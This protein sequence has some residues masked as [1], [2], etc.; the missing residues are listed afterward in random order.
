MSPSL[1]NV[2]EGKFPCLKAAQSPHFQSKVEAFAAKQQALDHLNF[3]ATRAHQ[4][5]NLSILRESLRTVAFTT[6]IDRILF[7]TLTCPQGMTDKQASKEFSALN[8]QWLRL[9]PGGYVRVIGYTKKGRPHIHAVVVADRDVQS[10]FDHQRYDEWQSLTRSTNPLT[11][12]Q[13]EHRTGLAENLST[14]ENLKA[15]TAKLKD[16]LDRRRKKL[17]KSQTFGHVV[18]LCPVRKNMEALGEYLERDFKKSVRR[19]IASL[20]AGLAESEGRSPGIRLVAY[21]GTFPKATW[22]TAGMGQRFAADLYPFTRALRTPREYLKYRFGP[23][24]A[25]YFRE[26]VLPDVKEHLGEDWRYQS[27]SDLAGVFL[28][29]LG[30]LDVWT[31]HGWPPAVYN[32]AFGPTWREQGFATYSDYIDNM[33]GPLMAA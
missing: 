29:Y 16:L 3:N 15:L 5:R 32:L 12:A 18:E 4:W 26:F 24:W 20:M 10:G 22:A 23:K 11:A 7:L 6:P 8:R 14:N 21:G 28:R 9:F 25:F 19:G 31:K 1:S 2:S 27:M 13:K 17:G 30:H 33:I